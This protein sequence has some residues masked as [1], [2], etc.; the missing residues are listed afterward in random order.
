MSTKIRD[1]ISNEF[2]TKIFVQKWMTI[3]TVGDFLAVKAVKGWKG[4]D[5]SGN[6]AN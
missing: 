6:F 4:C 2:Q 5:Y 3:V 1:R